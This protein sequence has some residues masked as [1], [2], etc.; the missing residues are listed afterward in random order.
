METQTSQAEANRGTTH[1]FFR[2]SG[3]ATSAIFFLSANNSAE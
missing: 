1:H 2:A 3:T